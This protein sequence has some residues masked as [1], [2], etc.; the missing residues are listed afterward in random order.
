MNNCKQL[1]H[2]LD[3][4]TAFIKS[5]M[6][7]LEDLLEAADIVSEDDFYSPRNRKIWSVCRELAREQR[8][9]D[10]VTLNQRLKGKIPASYLAKVIDS[11]PAS[12]I[13]HY[14]KVIRDLAALRRAISEA[15]KIQQLCLDPN[16]DPAEVVAEA[17]GRFLRIEQTLLGKNSWRAMPELSLRMSGKYERLKKAGNEI[18]G[19]PSG[20]PDL[21]FL[22]AG[23]QPSD[24]II[25]A[26][27]PSMGKTALLVSIIR[28]VARHG[29]PIAFFSL[30]QPETQ[31]Y[32]RLASQLTG[33]NLH[34]FRSGNFEPDEMDKIQKAHE[35]IFEWPLFI[36]GTGGLHYAE[37]RRR[38]RQAWKKHKVRLILVDYLGLATGDGN[39]GR[40]QEVASISRALKTLAKELDVPIIALSQLSRAVESRTDKRPKLSDLRDSGSIEQDADVVLFI[41]RDEVYR[42]NTDLKGIAEI[43][44]AKQRNGPTGTINLI[45]REKIARFDSAAR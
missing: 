22:T 13:E 39:R 24:L 20:F 33:I 10:L 3:H 27:R 19:I 21:D 28:N 40:E 1:P 16:R 14:A 41:Y 44:I 5:T 2:S 11:P 30:E 32:S 8:P 43:D 31:I 45:W 12:T 6:V 23:F 15:H 36:D 35:T 7:D 9:A 38:A 4:E 29:I 18:T 42:P 17:Q 26:A 25:L 34:K 37:I